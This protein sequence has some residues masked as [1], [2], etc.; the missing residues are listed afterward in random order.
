MSPSRTAKVQ[1]EIEKTK[2]KISDQQAKLREL[3]AKRTEIEN[4]EI[5]DIVRGLSIPLDQLAVFLQSAKNG[6]PLPGISSGHFVQ[7]LEQGGNPESTAIA[8]TESIGN[9]N[10]SG[11]SD[12]NH[13]HHNHTYHKEG[14]TQ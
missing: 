2:G 13:N 4:S 10:D 1:A 3:E 7:S 8:E 12:N 9:N 11:N 14:Q 6:E 5:V